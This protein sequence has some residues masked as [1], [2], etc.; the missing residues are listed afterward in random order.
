M[1]L[2]KM[3]LVIQ[4]CQC[5][6]LLS[7]VAFL[8]QS[9]VLV[10]PTFSAKL[11]ACFIVTFLCAF[12]GLSVLSNTQATGQLLFNFLTVVVQKEIVLG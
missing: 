4:H 7:Q 1:E 10:C 6:T 8:C 11:D 5:H 2:N 9:T 12:F 3:N